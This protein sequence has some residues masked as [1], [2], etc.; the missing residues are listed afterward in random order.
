MILSKR[1]YGIFYGKHTIGERKQNLKKY[2]SRTFF[3]ERSIFL[4]NSFAISK[5]FRNFA[6]GE[7]NQKK[8]TVYGRRTQNKQC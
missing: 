6:V 4:R 2:T 7:E 3:L 5:K 1:K 8:A